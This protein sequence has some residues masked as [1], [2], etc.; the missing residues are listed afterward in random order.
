MMVRLGLTSAGL[1]LLSACSG[2]DAST[3]DPVAPPTGPDRSAVRA[4]S[5]LVLED[6]LTGRVVAYSHRD[7]WHG[8]PVVQMASPLLLRAWFSNEVRDADDHDAPAQRSWFRLD[9]LSDAAAMNL[10]VVIADTTIASW[11]GAASGGSLVG[12]RSNQ[13]SLATFVA[14]RGT[15][16]LNERPPLNVVTR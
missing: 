7:H 9:E 2:G 1:V 6:S 13:A 5:E 10:R 4:T 15:T 14:R 16:T 3:P 8:F 12:L 11:R